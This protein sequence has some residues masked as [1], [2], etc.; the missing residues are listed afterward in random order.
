ME[1]CFIETPLGEGEVDLPG[2]FRALD[3]IGYDGY[4]TIE[5]EVGEDPE[6]DIAR[7]VR[8]IQGIG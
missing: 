6:A 1:E 3:A 8:F 5:R 7:A 2:W 4:Y